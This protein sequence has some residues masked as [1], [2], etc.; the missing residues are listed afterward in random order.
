MH[1]IRLPAVGWMRQG[2]IEATLKFR[3]EDSAVIGMDGQV[4]GDVAVAVVIVNDIG[5]LTRG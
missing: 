1:G 3:E 4:P 2:R 5:E